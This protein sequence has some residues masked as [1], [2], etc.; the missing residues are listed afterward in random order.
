MA[1]AA[2][3]L[4]GA[5]ASPASATTFVVG[6]RNCALSNGNRTLTCEG[7]GL[8]G[9]NSGWPANGYFRFSPQV[10]VDVTAPSYTTLPQGSGTFKYNDANSG[11]E[12]T[13]ADGTLN[14]ETAARPGMCLDIGG[15]RNNGD[16]AFIYR[17][18][19]NANQTFVVDRGYIKVKNTL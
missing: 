11:E 3:A 7:Y 9:G 15:T 16:N 19:Y 6:L 1:V 5:F 17:C 14:V 10:T 13:I 18:A 4:A 8:N 12:Y 2:M